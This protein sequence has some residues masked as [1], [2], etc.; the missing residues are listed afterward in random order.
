MNQYFISEL[1]HVK[2]ILLLIPSCIIMHSVWKVPKMRLFS[3]T[4]L[5]LPSLQLFEEGA[6][7]R[8]NNRCAK[9][10]SEGKVRMHN[11][12]KSRKKVS[13]YKH[14]W[15]G[16][17][18]MKIQIFEFKINNDFLVRKFKSLNWLILGIKIENE[19]FL[20]IFKHCD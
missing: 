11:V 20:L 7:V 10:I 12:W 4:V 1:W 9:Y 14:L 2:Y 5:P 17:F 13:F 16:I 19:T 3:N 18:G 6:K 8:R 15:G